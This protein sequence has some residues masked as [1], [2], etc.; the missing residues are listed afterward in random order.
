[1]SISPTFHYMRNSSVKVITPAVTFG[2]HTTPGRHAI[3]LGLIWWVFTLG[4]QV[5]W[6]CRHNFK[7]KPGVCSKC[8]YR[9]RFI[10]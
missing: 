5:T 6:R 1:M 2:H 3:E 4:L 7:K 8:N 9:R 10:S